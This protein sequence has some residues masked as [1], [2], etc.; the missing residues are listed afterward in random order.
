[1]IRGSSTWWL[2]GAMLVVFGVAIV[3]FPD[4]LALMVASAFILIGA[5][6]LSIAYAARKAR[7]NSITTVYGYDRWQPW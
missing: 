6:W 1:M 2:P 5:S 7:R 4:L 3:L